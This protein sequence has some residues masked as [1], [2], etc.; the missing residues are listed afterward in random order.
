MKKQWFRTRINF[1][2][3]CANSCTNWCT[4]CCK[5]SLA[6]CCA[7]AHTFHIFAKFALF[8]NI[9][10]VFLFFKKSKTYIKWYFCNF[11]RFKKRVIF[12]EKKI[13]AWGENVEKISARMINFGVFFMQSAAKSYGKVTCWHPLLWSN[14][15]DKG[16]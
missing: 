13:S 7:C 8:Y 3:E 11:L 9:F 16:K 12:F 1:F 5:F 2:G 10:F 14:D 15:L 6:V 4:K